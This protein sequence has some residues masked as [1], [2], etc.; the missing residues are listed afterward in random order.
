MLLYKLGL[1]EIEKCAIFG[2]SID[3]LNCKLGLVEIE[4]CAILC[5][6]A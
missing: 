6:V 3:T 1:V 4:K 2:G 5:V